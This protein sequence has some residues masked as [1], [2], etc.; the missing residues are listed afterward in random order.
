MIYNPRKRSRACNGSVGLRA[1]NHV[2]S[3]LETFIFISCIAWNNRYAV[4]DR[5]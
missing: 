1:R 5:N 4:I 3:D 2:K